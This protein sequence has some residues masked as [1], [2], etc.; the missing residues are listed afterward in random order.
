[1]DSMTTTTTWDA[2]LH[3]R[4]ATGR[5]DTKE[6]SA[7]ELSLDDASDD[8]DLSDF[9]QAP[10][11]EAPGFAVL[12]PVLYQDVNGEEVHAFVGAVRDD[13]WL[14]LSHREPGSL[15]DIEW[16]SDFTADPR[17]VRTDPDISTVV[18]ARQ[19][20]AVDAMRVN[21]R[22]LA[23][24]PGEDIAGINAYT[25]SLGVR[26]AMKVDGHSNHLRAFLDTEQA[27]THAIGELAQRDLIA[28][29]V[30]GW[31]YLEG[32]GPDE[33]Q[34]ACDAVD[35][36]GLIVARASV[37]AAVLSEYDEWSVMD[38][39]TVT[40]LQ[41]HVTSARDLGH[42]MSAATTAASGVDADIDT[43]G[44]DAEPRLAAAVAKLTESRAARYRKTV[45]KMNDAF[46]RLE[47]AEIIGRENHDWSPERHCAS[48]NDASV[49]GRAAGQAAILRHFQPETGLTDTELNRIDKLF[50]GAMRAPA[51]KAAA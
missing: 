27:A 38:V 13:G 35:D 14:V 44:D 45:A 24:A 16:E 39:E 40:G 34:G 23:D 37:Q 21:A 20:A 29:E 31:A 2:A 12:E 49:L 9:L 33:L 19:S 15:T 18:I 51:E 48:P 22:E 7:P 4:E 32:Y 43:L 5:F 50:N 41:Q 36:N 46:E 42:R 25:E 10:P 8:T 30:E 1:M 28:G 6:Q 17:Y 47:R 11:T 3:P 26:D